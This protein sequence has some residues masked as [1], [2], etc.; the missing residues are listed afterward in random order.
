MSERYTIR[1]ARNA[2][3]HL[4]KML[5]KTRF[6]GAKWSKNNPQIGTWRL[7]NATNYGGVVVEEIVNDGLGVGRPLG[8]LRKSPREFCQAVYFLRNS[9]TVLQKEGHLY[10]AQ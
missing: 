9:M 7:D 4:C 8:E 2:F 10:P 1:D 5:D 3:E 6:D